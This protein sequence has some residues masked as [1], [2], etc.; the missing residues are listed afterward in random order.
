LLKLPSFERLA[1]GFDLAGRI[2]LW[3]LPHERLV[4]AGFKTRPQLQVGM[5]VEVAEQTVDAYRLLCSPIEGIIYEAL[6]DLVEGRRRVLIPIETE[7]TGGREAADGDIDIQLV[8]CRGLPGSSELSCY[9]V[10][11]SNA[12]TRLSRRS[13]VRRSPSGEPLW[14]A[15]HFILPL[16][17]RAARFALDVRDLS[18]GQT[19]GRAVVSAMALAGGCAAFWAT[20]Y[21]GR[22]LAKRWAALAEPWRVTVPLEDPATQAVLPT[23][24]A[25]LSLSMLRWIYKPEAPP[26]GN[27]FVTPGA[28]S[29]IVRVLEGYNVGP[30]GAGTRFVQVKYNNETRDTQLV[31]NK[32]HPVWNRTFVFAENQSAQTRRLRLKILSTRAIAGLE[33]DLGFLHI[34]LDTI[35]EREPLDAWL[36]LGGNPRGRLHVAAEIVPG[37]PSSSAVTER[38]ALEWRS[39]EPSLVV[40]VLQAR[41]L[42]A[43]G[44]AGSGCLFCRVVYGASVAETQVVR[45]SESPVFQHKARLPLSGRRCPLAIRCFGREIARGDESLGSAELDVGSL[46][47]EEGR[48]Y[49]AVVQLREGSGSSAVGQVLLKLSRSGKFGSTAQ[50]AA[51]SD[52]DDNVFVGSFQESVG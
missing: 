26:A 35:Y 14:R 31:A 51:G 7:P 21:D 52:E 33:Q 28:R 6:F 19:I 39:G 16:G 17:D 34:N 5:Q 24:E 12:E 1:T 40:E 45:S 27:A 18:T 25:T 10:T 8:G 13:R 4:M 29:I 30:S 47:A 41:G 42:S 32:M 46:L 38:A 2:Q 22:P 37:I 50:G 11:A 20:A 48:E 15:Q 36:E 43:E 9:Q 44:G 3:T 49:E 23:G